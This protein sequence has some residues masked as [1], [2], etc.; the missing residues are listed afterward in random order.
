MTEKK[1]VPIV[2]LTMMSVVSSAIGFVLSEAAFRIFLRKNAPERF[3]TRLDT[4][5]GVYDKSHWIYD[6]EAGYGYPPSRVI[7]NAMVTPEGTITSCGKIDVINENGSIG[8]IV[9]NFDQAELKIS[10][11]GD[12]WTAFNFNGITW[13]HKF[14]TELQKATGRDVHVLN[15]GRDGYGILQMIDLAAREVEKKKPDIAIIAFIT[16][17]LTRVRTWRNETVRDG[18]ERVLTTFAPEKDPKQGSFYDTYLLHPGLTEEKC[19]EARKQGGPSV[20]GKEI[21]DRYGRTERI[22]ADI[23][24]DV[25]TLK[26]SFL[27]QRVTTGNAFNGLTS[28]SGFPI[29]K[30]NDYRED[31]QFVRNLERIKK[32]GTKLIFWHMAFYPEVQ[33]QEEYI[34]NYTEEALLKSLPAASGLPVEETLKY[35]ALPVEN[36]ERMNASATNYH[37]SQ[38]GQQ[39][40]AE[41]ATKMLLERGYVTKK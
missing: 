29:L 20:I 21:I 28:L 14:Q 17:D 25:W 6:E 5:I 15:Y 35:V 19:E 10:V 13:T 37:P 39:F 32:S 18:F 38:W 27:W 33:K 8:P 41:A 24:A 31:P 23:T 4:S 36:A 11:F 40:Y 34:V 9:G 12:S 16:N 3:E 26:H 2:A 30:L 1:W 22:G 7:I